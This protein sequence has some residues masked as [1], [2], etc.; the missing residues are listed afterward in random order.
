M[1]N[2]PLPLLAITA[3]SGTGKTTLLKALIPT[4]AAMGIRCG[5]IKHSHH[6][7]D[8]DTPG[9]DSYELRKA[10]AA[11]T[12]VACDQ[13]WALMTETPERAVS[14]P[15]LVNKF[16]PELIDLVLLEG[17]KQEAV[18]KIALYRAAVG[19]PLADLLDEYAIAI[20]TD[21][22]LDVDIPVLNI[23]D[24]P[25]IAEFIRTWLADKR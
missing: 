14:L 25:Q 6:N 24:C 20:A 17:F 23:N 21:E 11:Q 15:E 16:N 12:I 5:L 7:V 9:K 3:Y 22:A 10:G 19:R 8:V 2:A 18:P 1:T 4:L 13:R